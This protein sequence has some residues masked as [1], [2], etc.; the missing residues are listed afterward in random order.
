V[1]DVFMK[2]SKSGHGTP[3]VDERRVLERFKAALEHYDEH[4]GA[5]ETR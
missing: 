1:L 4:F 5:D 2:R 3:R